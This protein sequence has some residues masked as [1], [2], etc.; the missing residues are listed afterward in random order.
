[1]TESLMHVR[2]RCIAWS[3]QAFWRLGCNQSGWVVDGE[4][5]DRSTTAQATVE[6]V[7]RQSS[8]AACHTKWGACGAC[9]ELAGSAH[10]AL[11]RSV[12]E[13]GSAHNLTVLVDSAG[14]AA[15]VEQRCRQ[16]GLSLRSLV[17]DGAER[18][19]LWP[20][21]GGAG[22]AGAGVCMAAAAAAGGRSAA[23]APARARGE[24]RRGVL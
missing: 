16:A 21:V 24:D 20:P 17:T 13:G 9:Y 14:G 3:T 2:D 22:G 6:G 10:I 1:M 8:M 5:W 18:K 19:Q 12:N 7:V 15:A 23:L 11:P 4:V